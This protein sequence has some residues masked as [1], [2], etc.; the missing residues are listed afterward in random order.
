[1][2]IKRWKK[3]PSNNKINNEVRRRRRRVWDAGHVDAP[4][5]RLYITSGRAP[6]TN[7]SWPIDN[8][9]NEC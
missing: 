9:Q 3:K 6:Y 7:G 5:I 2:Y 8:N 4:R 1:M